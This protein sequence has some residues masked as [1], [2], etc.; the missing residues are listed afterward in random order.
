MK[1][2]INDI[3]VK[4]WIISNPK[5]YERAIAS[6][7]IDPISISGLRVLENDEEHK[8]IS[9]HWVAPPAYKTRGGKYQTIFWLSDKELWKEIEMKIIQEYHAFLEKRPNLK[10]GSDGIPIIEE[11]EYGKYEKRY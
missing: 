6:I 7:K 4:I 9:T 5:G 8:A 11:G 10:S 2:N 3:K 1:I